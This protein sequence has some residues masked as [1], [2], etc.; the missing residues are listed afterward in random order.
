[1]NE[2]QAREV[3][4][5]EAFET[6]QPAAASWSDDDRA[7]ADRVA[8]EAFSDDASH[9]AAAD[10]FVA[11]RASHA[12]QRLGPRE[13]ALARGAGQLAWRSGWVVVI[14]V[15]A[16]ILGVAAD[17]I[18]SDQRINLLAPPLWGVLLW[19]AVVYVLLIVWPLVQLARR[20][21]VQKEGPLVRATESLLRRRGRLPRAS[22]GGSAAA[23]RHFA[24]LWLERSRPLAARRAATVLHAGAAALALGLVAG[25]YARGLVLDYRAAWE[26]T[27]L[28]A[29]IAH[30]LVT[31]VLGPASQLSGI[32][33]PDATAFAALRAEHGVA[34]VGAPAAPWIHLIA[35]TLL[36]FVVLPRS[37]LALVGHALAMTRVRRFAL[38]LETPYYQRLLR[39]RRSG[40]ARASVHPYGAVPA[41]QATLG[42]RALLVAALGPRLDM[43]VAP[44]VGFGSE[45]EA[46]PRVEPSITHAVVLFDLGATP[47]G[48]N[49]G[50]FLRAVQA[51]V[52]GGAA[53][54]VI[55]DA[56][57]FARRFTGLGERM[58]ERREAWRAW[59]EAHGVAPVVVDLEAADAAAAGPLL[60][61]A[62]ASPGAVPAT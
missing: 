23:V 33:L 7:W 1:M 50:R 2:R 40:P 46:L 37:V 9:D 19:N 62:F 29:P 3:T 24:A 53:V 36:G 44:A 60:Q 11:G 35:I 57:S 10:A 15:V 27:F 58:A 8:L 48:E 6:A 12:L 55:V 22:A 41:P 34:S 39:L 42:L 26:S 4:W 25:M 49:Q 45:D 14:G 51:A 17:A 28:S 47:E 20:G 32:A 30:A 31:G 5:L 61:A 16:F 54:A 43:N 13:P 52:P 56:A 38:P 59:G 18:G 21:R